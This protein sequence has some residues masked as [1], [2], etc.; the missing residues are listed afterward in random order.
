MATT[1][2][3]RGRPRNPAAPRKP[4][5]RPPIPFAG[6]PRGWELALT[7]WTVRALVAEGC[8][9]LRAI[10]SYVTWHALMKG[11]ARILLRPDGELEAEHR[12]KRPGF[13]VYATAVSPKLLAALIAKH[14]KDSDWEYHSENAFRPEVR[15]LDKK[16]SA[17]N[18]T[19]PRRLQL[20]VDAW[21]QYTLLNREGARR[22]AASIGEAETFERERLRLLQRWAG[23]SE[24]IVRF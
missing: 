22:I 6:D 5:G 12:H 16:L 23:G 17:I 14:V 3:A 21:E 1:R 13:W 20:M 10:D 18:K 19:D 2:G 8:S 7:E 11:A 15:S 24:F 4:V 9:R